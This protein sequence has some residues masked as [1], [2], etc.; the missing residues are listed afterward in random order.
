MLSELRKWE[1][2]E[3]IKKQQVIGV[4]TKTEVSQKRKIVNES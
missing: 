4:L 2:T 3:F 1:A